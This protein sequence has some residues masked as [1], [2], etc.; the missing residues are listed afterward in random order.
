MIPSNHQELYTSAFAV[1]VPKSFSIKVATPIAAAKTI[2]NTAIRRVE[3]R[4][5]TYF[6]MNQCSV[7]TH[8]KIRNR[9]LKIPEIN[10]FLAFVKPI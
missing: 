8:A 3:K 10:M 9:D 1:W 6:F 7:K 5:S 2:N 4:K